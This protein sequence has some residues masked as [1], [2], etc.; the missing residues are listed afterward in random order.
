MSDLIYYPRLSDK[1]YELLSTFPE[2]REK[3]IASTKY[4]YLIS[5]ATYA[6]NELEDQL[7]ECVSDVYYMHPVNEMHGIETL[8]EI[9]FTNKDD[10]LK[11]KIKFGDG[12]SFENAR[13]AN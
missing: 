7:V 2:W 9:R 3:Y 10:A 1:D 13:N 11:F 8:W 12:F 5:W 4:K 6:E